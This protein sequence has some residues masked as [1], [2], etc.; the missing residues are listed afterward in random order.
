MMNDLESV[1]ADN[2]DELKDGIGDIL[3]CVARLAIAFNVDMEEALAETVAEYEQRFPVDK[4]KGK[5]GNRK[6]G[7]HDGKYDS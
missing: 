7:G 3:W 6:L 4:V 2:R 1:I 5:H